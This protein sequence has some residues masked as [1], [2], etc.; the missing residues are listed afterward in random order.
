MKIVLDSNIIVSAFAS[1]GLCNSLFELSIEK[2]GTIINSQI[3][4][5]ITKVFKEKIKL[6]DD[7]I[8]LI[9]EYL[10]EYCI[11]SEHDQIHQKISRDR[12]DD[13]IISLAYFN[14]AEYIVTGDKDLLDI[15]KYESVKI[16]TPR[17]FW[18]ISKKD[19]NI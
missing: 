8:R 14:S 11:F 19:K 6:P 12:D 13:G 16:V 2:Y 9:I 17:E 18:E 7:K 1:R 4:E 15:K 3:I 10:N 5:E